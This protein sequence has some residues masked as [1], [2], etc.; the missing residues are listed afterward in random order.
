[1][2]GKFSFSVKADGGGAD[3]ALRRLLE[4]LRATADAA[5]LDLSPPPAKPPGVRTDDREAA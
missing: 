1:M 4:L 5:L 3:D 2:S